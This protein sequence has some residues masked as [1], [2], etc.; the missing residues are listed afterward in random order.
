MF[1]TALAPNLLAVDLI[2][3]TINVEITWMTWFLGFLPA[4]VVLLLATPL[5]L[6]RFYPPGIR[7][8]SD[9]PVWAKN[10]LAV[11][12]P[13]SRKEL[14]LAALAAVALLL[15]VGGEG[16]VHTTIVALGAVCLMVLT[17]VVSWEDILSNTPAWDVLV[18][19]ASL[20]ALAD[21]LTRVG[22]SAWLGAS[23]AAFL[24]GLS[25]LVAMVVIVSA[26]F[27]THYLFASVTAHVVAMLPLFLSAGAAVP[28]MNV[29]VLTLLLAYSLGVM[30]ILTPYATG[31]SP[32]YY[33]SGFI[34]RR[35]FW[36][37]G[38]VCGV[39]FLA[40][41]LGLGIPFLSAIHAE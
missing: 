9:I 24:S 17:G 7:T 29:L 2:G 28:G 19:F 13:P 1:M 16:S 40:M 5:L 33:G 11:L 22:F 6:H 18:W 14:V 4:G 26:F 20:V 35:D 38:L 39:L 3:K 8:S 32:I 30:G 21:G 15:W 34:P 41:L 23:T 10:Q 12:G 25:P 27:M 31:P 36:L 37:L